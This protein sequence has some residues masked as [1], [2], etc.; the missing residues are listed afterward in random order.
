M[1]E[2]DPP[3]PDSTTTVTPVEPPKE[4]AVP[5]AW[6]SSKQAAVAFGPGPA[7]VAAPG[8]VASP[9]DQ[10]AVVLQGAGAE[11]ITVVVPIGA[12][13]LTAA[14]FPTAA[15]VPPATPEP[16]TPAEPAP[17]V[18]VQV[19][20][21]WGGKKTATAF[22]GVQKDA[23]L[24]VVH[25]PLAS[26][27]GTGKAFFFLFGFKIASETD[28]MMLGRELEQINDDI[29]V[30]RNAGYTVV[31]DPQAARE[32]F[33]ATL[34]SEGAGEGVAGLI[35]AGF[36]WSAHGHSDGGIE[37]CDGSLVHANEVDTSKVSAGLR[38]AI[39]GACY[40]GARSMTWKKALGGRA[41]VVGWGRPVTIERAVDFLEPDDA[42]NTDLDDLIRRW[43]LTDD[44]LPDDS[45]EQEGVPDSPVKRGRIGE[46]TSRIATISEMLGARWREVENHLQLEVPLANHRT[47]LVD[48]FV[49]D[50]SEPF[51]EGELLFGAE[52]N[53][54]ELT[55]L[56]DVTALLSNIGHAGYGR[57]ALVKSETD[58]PRIVAQAFAPL[59]RSTD[60]HLAAHVFQVAS[61]ADA[62]E[63][64]IFG[65][66]YG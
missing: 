52:S 4:V 16:T 40:V 37:T 1:S 36:Y 44:P 46:L 53:I 38:L 59:S 64:Q 35:P 18:E 65:G 56:T 47:Q 48:V 7:P 60:Q 14:A 33:T 3:S 27:I 8:P 9:L 28:Q 17:A 11:P 15:A 13:E 42:T 23:S 51:C 25:A 45:H 31:V 39:F 50:A 19:P 63:F 12:A 62:L 61:K 2:V 22:M 30:L 57:I 6:G 24:R 21:A 43:L 55:A 49:A 34:Y 29:E 41:L 26:G 58:M 5:A 66:D 20:A 10:I 32:D 54:G